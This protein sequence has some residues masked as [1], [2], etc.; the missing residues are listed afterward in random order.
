[1]KK[2]SRS[3]QTFFRNVKKNPK[4]ILTGQAKA[5]KLNFLPFDSWPF[6]YF[7][8]NG[9]YKLVA[10]VANTL[11]TAYDSYR[12]GKQGWNGIFPVFSLQKSF[13]TNWFVVQER[14]G[15]FASF[16]LSFGG[17]I[18]LGTMVRDERGNVGGEIC[19]WIE[20]PWTANGRA[21]IRS[22]IFDVGP[23]EETKLVTNGC[24]EFDVLSKSDSSFYLEWNSWY[25]RTCFSSSSSSC[26]Y[27]LH[28]FRGL[29][30]GKIVNFAKMV[31]ITFDHLGNKK[32]LV[33]IFFPISRYFPDFRDCFRFLELLLRFQINFWQKCW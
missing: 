30:W 18:V 10:L 32:I 31:I 11:T 26:W 27:V 23:P 14:N 9:G 15:L 28:F 13:R 21:L 3:H 12:L 4:Q 19:V 7:S 29:F 1:M 17:K 8:E 22:N 25:R 6:S 20:R 33:K 5:K 2:K 16:F 24:L